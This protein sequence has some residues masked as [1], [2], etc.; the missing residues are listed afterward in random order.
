M[1]LLRLPT[2]A[3]SSQRRLFVIW[4]PSRR[5]ATRS[6]PFP[7]SNFVNRQEWVPDDSF[8]RDVFMLIPVV[9]NANRLLPPNWSYCHLSVI[10]VL[11]VPEL[12]SLTM[13][14]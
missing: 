7:Y 10:V 2:V 3:G 9:K 12:F 4:L 11:I 13:V 14:V 8:L 5:L 1:R 6:K